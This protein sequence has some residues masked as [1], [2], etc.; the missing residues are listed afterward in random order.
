MRPA[1]HAM[2]QLG[3]LHIAEFIVPIRLQVIVDP[4]GDR[5]RT[6]NYIDRIDTTFTQR[7]PQGIRSVSRALAS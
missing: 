6:R 5:E 3:N 2:Q 7:R 1:G 4:H